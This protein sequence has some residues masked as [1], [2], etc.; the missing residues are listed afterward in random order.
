MDVNGSSYSPKK[1]PTMFLCMSVFKG[2][3]LK[4][5][6]QRVPSYNQAIPN[7]QLLVW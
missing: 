4:T 5:Y 6:H 1:G 3:R 2:K 7:H